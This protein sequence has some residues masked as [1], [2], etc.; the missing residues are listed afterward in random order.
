MTDGELCIR[1]H[2]DEGGEFWNGLMER[3]T[4]NLMIMQTR[5]EGYDPDR[6]SAIEA[7]PYGVSS[8]SEF[9]I[10]CGPELWAQREEE[11]HNEILKL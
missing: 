6:L 8:E 11:S 5:T 7:E 1:I 3:V 10:W 9:P 4:N 2:S